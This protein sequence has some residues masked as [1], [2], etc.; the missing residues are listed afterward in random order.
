[1]RHAIVQGGIVVNVVLAEPEFAAEQGWVLAP[2]EVSTGWLYD[3]STFSPP[4][5][6][7]RDP[8]EIQAEIEAAVQK[9][10]DDFAATRYYN[11]ILS[12]CTYAT[13]AVPRFKTEGQYCVEARDATW[14][15]CYEIL[16]AVQAGTRPM[17]SGY[18]DIEGELPV[19]A[20]PN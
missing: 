15:K 20:W 16:T 4:P 7:V 9:R 13:S 18:A 11:G 19:L 14:A 17:P 1:M 2:D 12:A 3:G 8:A 10:L 6:I 5:P